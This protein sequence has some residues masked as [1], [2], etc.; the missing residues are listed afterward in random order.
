MPLQSRDT[1]PQPERHRIY[2]S[3]N[4]LRDISALGELINLIALDL[5]MNEIDDIAAL[6]GLPR[7]E[8]L[9]LDDNNIS[10][11]AP[12]LVNDE[13]EEG[14]SVSVTNNAL[15][16]QDATT[17]DILNSLRDRGVLLTSDCD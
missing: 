12:L 11:I 2:L 1:P 15:E 3:S 13:L 9:Y 10:D 4:D 5:S 14:D 17:R 8:T 6:A 16:C 7:L